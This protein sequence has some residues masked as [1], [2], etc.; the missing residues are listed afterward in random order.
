MIRLPFVRK[1][2]GL[3]IVKFVKDVFVKEVIPFSVFV[4]ISAVLVT[5]LNFAFSFILTFAIAIP[6]YIV[7]IY[8]FGITEVE[9]EIINSILTKVIKKK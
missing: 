6:I 9:R 1:T 2:G 4:V 5:Y 8:L 3:N 7:T